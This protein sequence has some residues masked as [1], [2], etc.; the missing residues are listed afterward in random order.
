MFPYC[1]MIE[2]GWVNKTNIIA[3]LG[4]FEL[5]LQYRKSNLISTALNIPT[6]R[7]K[8]IREFQSKTYISQYQLLKNLKIWITIFLC[9]SQKQKLIAF[10]LIVGLCTFVCL[11]TKFSLMSFVVKLYFHIVRLHSKIIGFIIIKTV[12]WWSVKNALVFLNLKCE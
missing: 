2:E 4:F 6:I 9:Y 11:L 10:E 8:I 12:I 1:W 7:Q 3:L 5:N